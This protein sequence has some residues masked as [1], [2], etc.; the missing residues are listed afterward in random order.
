MQIIK[1]KHCSQEF[2]Q[3]R[4][5]QVY[6][7]RSCKQN[8]SA[9]RTGRYKRKRSGSGYQVI[10]KVKCTKCGFLPIHVCQLDIDHI[11]GNNKNNAPENLQVLCANCHRL[12]TYQNKDWLYK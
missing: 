3:K 11:D 2:E 10:E 8:A 1:C 4:T 12:K 5:N 9:A 6:C 7:K